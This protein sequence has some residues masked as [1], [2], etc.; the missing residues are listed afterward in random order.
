MSIATI[1][2]E[3]PRW[4]F[5]W[6][7]AFAFFVGC[8]AL[9]WWTT[10]TAGISL[11]RQIGYLIAWPGLDAKAFFHTLRL[12]RPSLRAWLSAVAKLLLGVVLIA[13]VYPRLKDE[14]ELVRGWVGM[15][16][17]VFV[18]HFGVFHLLSLA[19][20]SVGVSAR[21]IMDW[22][23]QA[24]S[25]SEFWGQRWNRAFRDL[26][27]RY[28]FR[29][30]TTRFGGKVALAAGFLFSGVVHD[31]VI[32]LPAGGG[33]GG[34]TAFFAIQAIAIFVERSALGQRLGLGRGI[35]GWA[36]A[37]VTLLGPIALLFPPPFL[38]NVIVPFLDY[39]TQALG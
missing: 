39:I 34:P 36:F 4:A 22:P 29:P 38:R 35:R 15:L 1:F 3:E 20:Q 11:G 14:N 23:I 17:I 18:L 6:Q 8:K 21:P 33:Y 5:M 7:L 31:L 24:T 12:E 2:G 27:H 25:V 30:L 19:W 32:S 9:T 13:D 10:P 28:V 26:T 37:L 16:G